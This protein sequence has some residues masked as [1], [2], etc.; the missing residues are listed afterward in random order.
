[1]AGTNPTLSFLRPEQNRYSILAHSQVMFALLAGQQQPQLYQQSHL[2]FTL[3]ACDL[4][5]TTQ[6]A[7]KE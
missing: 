6:L 1:M 3:R 2:C 7:H 5:V 4:T